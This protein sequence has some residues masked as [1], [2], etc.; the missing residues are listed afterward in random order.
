MLAFVA[1]RLPAFDEYD[2]LIY[3]SASHDDFLAKLDLAL[4]ETAEDCV[5]RRRAAVA[6]SSWDKLGEQMAGMLAASSREQQ[7]PLAHQENRSVTS[8]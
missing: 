5:A 7:K 1:V 4:N 8:L 3:L 2:E 6:A